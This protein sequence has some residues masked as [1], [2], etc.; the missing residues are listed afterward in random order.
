MVELAGIILGDDVLAVGFSQFHESA[1]FVDDDAALL[2][3]QNV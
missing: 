3:L 2:A 1:Q